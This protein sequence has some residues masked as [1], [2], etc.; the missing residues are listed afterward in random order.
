[1]TPPFGVAIAT[2]SNARCLRFCLKVSPRT[3]SAG[4]EAR[5]P[6]VPGEDD[7][8]VC[9]RYRSGGD[10][11][12]LRAAFLDCR[13]PV[14]QRGLD[15][16]R[17]VLDPLRRLTATVG[18]RHYR[19][20]GRNG[21]YSGAGGDDVFCLACQHR[22]E[23]EIASPQVLFTRPDVVP[24]ENTEYGDA[25]GQQHR[26]GRRQLP[27]QV[28]IELHRGPPAPAAAPC[29]PRPRN[30]I[31]TAV[32]DSARNPNCADRELGNGV[33]GHHSCSN[34]RRMTQHPDQ[35]DAAARRRM[36]IRAVA[37]S[38]IGTTI[39]W[40]DFFLYGVAAALVFPQK[41]FPA[42]IRSS[43]RCCR[44]R[45]S[46]SAS[47]PGR[48]ARRSSATSATASAARPC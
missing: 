2:V 42:R 28:G 20:A 34:R 48:S 39:E 27:P 5:T 13:L 11:Q 6:R 45:P 7:P 3:S 32:N 9:A 33:K 26:A 22:E 19:P 31:R 36:M 29:S 44:F 8:A 17:R 16:R 25:N 10:G 41:F 14:G 21:G 18:L 35:L 24:V 43:G 46:S 40:Y 37:A 4:S 38:A 30:A 47:R 15:P 12:T 23:P 1:M